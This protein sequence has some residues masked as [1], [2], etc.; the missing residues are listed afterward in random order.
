E[1]F[2]RVIV[3][4][5][6]SVLADDTPENVFA[7]ADV[8]EAARVEAPQL[9]RL[10][11]ALGW[12]TQPRTVTD[13]VD[14]LPPQNAA[15]RCSAVRSRSSRACSLECP[16]FSAVCCRGGCHSSPCSSCH[17]RSQPSSSSPPCCGTAHSPGSAAQPC[18]ASSAASPPPSAS[19]P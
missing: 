12:T 16:I 18:G 1:N 5:Q 19:Q 15:T 13:F 11:H 9:M 2:D 8:L 6:G 4:A 7:Q 10:A 3:M 17:R 14:Q